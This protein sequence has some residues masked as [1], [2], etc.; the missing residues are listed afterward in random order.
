MIEHLEQR[1]GE[2]K[3]A[4]SNHDKAEKFLDFKDETDPEETIREMFKWAMT[5]PDREVKQ[6][7]YELNKGMYS[8][9]K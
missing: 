6:M 1:L 8:Y 3:Y 2:A 7:D 5:Q 4:Y 9:W